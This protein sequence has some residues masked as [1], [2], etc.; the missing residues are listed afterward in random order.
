MIMVKCKFQAVLL[1]LMTLLLVSCA[2]PP[3]INDQMLTIERGMDHERFKS[4]IIRE[5]ISSFTLKHE[6]FSYS[7]E[8]Y[9]MQTGTETIPNCFYT[10]YGMMCIPFTYPISEDYFFIFGKDGLIFWG[11]LNEL[12]KED[13]KLI[14]QLA[15]LISEKYEREKL[16]Q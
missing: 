13:D 1:F 7:I 11:F 2:T 9:P 6:G 14:Q 16:K 8:I 10:E 12:Y 15:P 5:P 3:I 4:I